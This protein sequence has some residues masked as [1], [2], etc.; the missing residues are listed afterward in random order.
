MLAGTGEPSGTIRTVSVRPSAVRPVI[1][2]TSSALR[3]SIGTCRK[4][5]KIVKSIVDDG[6]AT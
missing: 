3:R 6:S 1:V 5:S 2:A 4:P